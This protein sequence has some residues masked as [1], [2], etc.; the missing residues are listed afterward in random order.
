MEFLHWGKH[1]ESRKV[2]RELLVFSVHRSNCTFIPNSDNRSTKLRLFDIS[3]RTEWFP[4]KKNWIMYWSCP[5]SVY[6]KHY[7]KNILWTIR[8][9]LD[10]V[11]IVWAGPFTQFIKEVGLTHILGNL[12]SEWDTSLFAEHFSRVNKCLFARQ[13][14]EWI[15]HKPICSTD[16]RV[17]GAQAR[18]LD[19]LLV[20]QAWGIVSN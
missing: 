12:S 11:P 13:V 14:I 1:G 19:S 18:S 15:E 17:N 10:K 5:N 9:T 20:E 6:R 3:N 8:S 4:R 7:F 16:Y 2:G